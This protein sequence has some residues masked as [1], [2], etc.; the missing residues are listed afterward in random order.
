MG[1]IVDLYA[2]HPILGSLAVSLIGGGIVV[3]FVDFLRW[4]KKYFGN[5]KLYRKYNGLYIVHKK[6]DDP[7]TAPP[8]FCF[9]VTVGG[10]RYN[11]FSICG[12]AVASNSKVS[13]K[14]SFDLN[15]PMHGY[16]YYRHTPKDNGWGNIRVQLAPD[17][18]ILSIHTYAIDESERHDPYVWR[19]GD[20]PKKF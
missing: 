11:E 4:L 5:R 18:K 3:V 15:L 16:G 10:S 7:K 19:K 8:E 12:L 14:I 9:E 6:Y 20:C 13:G 17:S 2:G 1:F